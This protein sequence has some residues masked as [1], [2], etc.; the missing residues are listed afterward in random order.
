MGDHRVKPGENDLETFCKEN[1][2]E[3]LL[4]E[5]DYVANGG[6]V[7]SAIAKGS[8]K[9]VWWK[10]S[11]G[12]KWDACVKNRTENLCGC[13]ICDGKRVLAGFNDLATWCL[14]NDKQY[15]LDEW[16]YE[17]NKGLSPDSIAPKTAKKVWWKCKKGHEWQASVLKRSSGRGCPVCSNR[18]VKDGENDFVTWC[19]ENNKTYLLDEWDYEKN[20]IDP[21]IIVAKTSVEVWWKCDKNHSYKA[22]VVHRTKDGSGCPICSSNQVLTGFNDL[23][24]WCKNKGKEFYLEEWDYERNGLLTPETV[25]KMSN[26]R[27]WWRCKKGHS[28]RCGIATRLRQESGCPN[29]A[30]SGTSFPEQTVAYYLSKSF[31]IKQ[32]YVIS[33][34]EI[35]IFL[36][37]Y[38]IGIEYD[39]MY[40]HDAKDVIARDK[41]K[42]AFCKEQGIILFR[43]KENQ[44]KNSVENNTIFYST[45]KDKAGYRGERF[46]K[47]ILALMLRLDEITGVTTIK[48]IDIAR[49]EL[50]IRERYVFQQKMNSVAV[51]RPDL[52][53]EWDTE[54]NH[55]LLPENFEAGSNAKVWWLC[56]KGH[57]WQATINSRAKGNN[58]CPICSGKIILPGYNDLASWCVENNKEIYLDEWDY[59][60]NG[61][62][63]PQSVAPKSK[64]KVWWKCAQG[65]SWAV[66]I[67]SRTLDG[68][69]C[70]YCFGRQKSLLKENSLKSVR[71]DLVPEWDS[72]KNTGLSPDSIYVASTAIVWWKCSKGHSWQ[73]SIKSR[74]RDNTGC[75][76][77][78]GKRIVAGVNDFETWCKDND[79]LYL[80]SEWDYEKNGLLTPQAVSPK[81]SKRVWWKCPKGHNWKV[82]IGNRAEGTNCPYCANRKVRAG[83]NDFEAWCL[84]NS[85]QDILDEWDYEKN[86][87]LTPQQVTA[88]SQKKVWWCCEKGHSWDASVHNRSIGQRCPICSNNRVLEGYNDLA[89]WCKKNNK[90]Y[91]IDEWDYKRNE[92]LTPQRIAPKSSKKV[93]WICAK[94]HN[95]QATV[96]SRTQNESGCP[97]CSRRKIIG[98]ENKKPAG[99]KNT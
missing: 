68:S 3:Y 57:S 2:L 26:K 55:G 89:T 76:I 97:L 13:P 58:G 48:D 65:H 70:P 49:D 84:H 23:A 73:A 79:K 41:K 88:H 86:N 69:C 44:H 33:G 52:V 85:R 51:V 39:G 95:W 38:N 66:V 92:S 61:A 15:L 27:V 74:T 14:K 62:I 75:L 54:K 60:K 98:I 37:E 6:L 9:K 67:S 99:G 45:T 94:D 18:K 77:C 21:Q 16:N 83:Y 4:S 12:H 11:L 78:S 31:N 8:G 93:W 59:E 17:M 32:R 50:L 30:G 25:A 29:C 81:S 43:I 5:W 40:Y 36:D 90:L 20:T 24:S 19:R 42:D 63:T 91:I 28:W 80:V 82:S 87:P 96:N 72:D 34:Y 53:S 46:A 22:T 64:K 71:P 10:C 47:A 56:C 1:N 35:D 7:P